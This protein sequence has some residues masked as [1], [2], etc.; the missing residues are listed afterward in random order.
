MR[1]KLEQRLV[2]RWPI[3]AVELGRRL[4]VITTQIVSLVTARPSCSSLPNLTNSPEYAPI[5]LPERTPEI[6]QLACDRDTEGKRSGG[7]FVC[8][9]NPRLLSN[10]PPA[11]AFS[12]LPS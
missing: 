1:K 2:A 3:R 11:Q 5:R 4:P 9:C 6:P 8:R 10:P 7:E 12:N